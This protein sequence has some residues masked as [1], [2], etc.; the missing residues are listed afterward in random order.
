MQLRGRRIQHRLQAVVI[1]PV[2]GITIVGG[3]VCP[4]RAKVTFARPLWAV[5]LFCG[6]WDLQAVH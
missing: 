2:V 1:T 5:I 3:M 4:S 6:H